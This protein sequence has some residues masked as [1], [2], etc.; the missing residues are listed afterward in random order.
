MVDR[1]THCSVLYRVLSSKL[2]DGGR[3]LRACLRAVRKILVP[4]LNLFFE[5]GCFHGEGGLH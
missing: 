4:L 2:I 1:G 3:A 5:M